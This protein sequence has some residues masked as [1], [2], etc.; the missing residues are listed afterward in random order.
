MKM[1]TNKMD[2]NKYS[3]V[4]NMMVYK[5]LPYLSVLCLIGLIY[6]AN[7]HFAEKNMQKSQK[8]IEELKELKSDYWTLRSGILYNSTEGQISKKVSDQEIYIRTEAP[9]KLIRKEN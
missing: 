8:L 4:S 1:E 6:I 3:S 2:R 5:N 7:V 9:K